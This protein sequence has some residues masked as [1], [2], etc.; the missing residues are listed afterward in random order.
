MLSGAHTYLRAIEDADLEPLR[1]W[2]NRPLMRRFFREHREISTTMQRRWFDTK[3]HNDP[4]TCMFAVCR[5]G[6]HQLLGAAGVCWID[7][8]ARSGDF[9]LYLGADDLYIDDVY[10]PDAGRVLLAYA[11]KD[12]GLNR[13]WAE[14]YHTDAAKQALLPALGFQGEGRHRQTTWKDGR[15]V[16]SLFYSVLAEEYQQPEPARRSICAEKDT[17]H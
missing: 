6:D 14:I 11:F 8:R 17:D 4:A 10:A 7:W 15:F 2:R 1:T 9:S 3:V 12:L 16:D 13:V 5:K